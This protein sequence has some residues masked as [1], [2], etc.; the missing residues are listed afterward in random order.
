MKMR[1]TWLR[2]QHL[3]SGFKFFGESVGPMVHEF[4]G[5]GE[6]VALRYRIPGTQW[7]IGSEITVCWA[8]EADVE[9]SLTGT[10]GHPGVPVNVNG[11][12]ATYHDGCWMPGPGPHQ[13]TIAGR[14]SAHWGSDFVHSLTLQTGKG[15]IGLRCPRA[16]VPHL[17]GLTDIL[18]SIPL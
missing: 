3:P 8:Q 4:N 2:P 12:T 7:G 18:A 1:N 11:K 6:Q 14:G 9:L 16:V 15:V 13:V 10:L 5:S 17:G